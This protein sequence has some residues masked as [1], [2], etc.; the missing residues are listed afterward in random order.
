MEL[1]ATPRHGSAF[2]RVLREQRTPAA[3]WPVVMVAVVSSFVTTWSVA[4]PLSAIAWII[5][6]ARP[7]SLARQGVFAT[8]RL[9][10]QD[11]G[12][13]RVEFGEAVS[14]LPICVPKTRR[15]ITR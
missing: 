1:V 8:G 11:P 5:T 9:I 4:L 12:S 15:S 3:W 10:E 6:Y 14:S 13:Y 7:R 2:R